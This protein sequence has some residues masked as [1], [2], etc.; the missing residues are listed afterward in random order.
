MT[1]QI[2][3]ELVE[4]LQKKEEVCIEAERVA[5]IVEYFQS[6]INARK[7]MEE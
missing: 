5:K 3:S 2:S 7:Y 1:E 6:K 4:Q